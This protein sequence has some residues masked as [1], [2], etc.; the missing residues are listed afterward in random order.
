MSHT[1]ILYLSMDDVE[2]IG[3]S[4]SD[5]IDTVEA[6]FA[7][8]GSNSVELPP[9]QEIRPSIKSFLHGMAAYVPNLNG[10]GLKY[11]SYLPGN[12]ETGNPDSTA[13]LIV[14]DP[15]K[16]YPVCIMEAMWI[17]YLR[18]ACMAAVAAKFC[19]NNS[20]QRV[21]FIGVGGL[22]RWTLPALEQVLPNLKEARAFARRQSSKEEFIKDMKNRVHCAIIP[23]QSAEEALEEADIVVSST[24]GTSEPFLIESW[25]KK[26]STAILLDGFASWE[27]TV[28]QKTDRLIYCDNDLPVKLQK[29]YPNLKVTSKQAEIGEIVLGKKLARNKLEDRVLAIMGGVGTIDV[30]MGWKIYKLAIEKGIGKTLKFMRTDIPLPPMIS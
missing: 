8:H 27:Q 1:E 13:V 25:W 21:A 19:A 11:I 7:E 29:L 17:T 6:T 2:N 16:L 9:K 18:T 26:G 4:F 5:C 15:Q 14:N 30:S 12:I 24:P 28:Y 10:L 23:A 22:A 3:F 20:A